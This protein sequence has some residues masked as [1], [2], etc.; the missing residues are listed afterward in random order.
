MA[1]SS[2]LPPSCD[3]T[4]LTS[5]AVAAF[6]CLHKA[7]H[8]SAVS[9][10]RFAG[11]E[12]EAL[13]GPGP[14]LGPGD[15]DHCGLCPTGAPCRPSLPDRPLTSPS[16]P[17]GCLCCLLVVSF[18]VKMT[19]PWVLFQARDT[20]AG[21]REFQGYGKG[22]PMRPRAGGQRVRVRACFVDR[23]ASDE[24]FLC[25]R[26]MP[27]AGVMLE[28]GATSFPERPFL[29]FAGSACS[30]DTPAVRFQQILQRAF[31]GTPLLRS[32]PTSLC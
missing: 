11:G 2:S 4:L 23:S 28:P 3:G 18:L 14:P 20:V 12:T 15:R 7:W 1:L 27:S 9:G 19:L 6:T 32:S 24:L 29:L 5:G 31:S 30:A 26:T 13:L 17:D 16:G 21:Q 10:P 8:S 25:V 22:M